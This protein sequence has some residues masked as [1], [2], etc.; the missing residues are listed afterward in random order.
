MGVILLL[1]Y[2]EAKE[3]D[4]DAVA[5]EGHVLVMAV[6]E[7]VENAGIHSGDATLV[8]PPQD[9]NQLTNDIDIS[10][11]ISKY[12]FVKI[13][14]I[15][16]VLG[17]TLI[18]KYTVNEFLSNT[19]KVVLQ[20]NELK[21]I[22]CN[23]R[24]SRSFPFVSKTLDFDFVA[25]ATRAMMV[26]RGKGRV[27]VKAPQFS[28]SRLAGADVMLGVEMASTGEASLSEGSSDAKTSSGTRYVKH[29]I[30]MDRVFAYRVSA[31]RSITFY[32]FY[33]QIL[34][35]KSLIRVIV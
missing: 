10:N 18:D 3:I 13:I 8:T 35:I 6:S 4:V 1:F 2:S 31:F 27:G 32:M 11:F 24:V 26:L 15:I 19:L 5:M 12:R 33:Q 17:L 21:V 23:L 25:L 16:S 9:I 34:K 7:H 14:K 20:D 30:K 29:I 22:E 28:F